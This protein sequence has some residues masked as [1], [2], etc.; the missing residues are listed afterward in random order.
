MGPSICIFNKVPS[1]ADDAGL[2]TTL[3]DLLLYTMR[4]LPTSKTSLLIMSPHT[5][6]LQ[7]GCQQWPWEWRSEEGG[8]CIP[9]FLLLHSLVCFSIP[10]LLNLF[11]TKL[12]WFLLYAKCFLSTTEDMT[13]NTIYLRKRNNI[14]ASLYVFLL[15]RSFCVNQSLPSFLCQKSQLHFTLLIPSL[16][17]YIHRVRKSPNWFSYSTSSLISHVWLSTGSFNPAFPSQTIHTMNPAIPAFQSSFR[18]HPSL[19][20]LPVAFSI[21]C[22]CLGLEGKAI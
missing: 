14:S 2:G 6:W 18:P 11:L 1:D 8:K 3:W 19:L 13:I 12:M 10:F 17:F 5:M 20:R 9:L 21:S 4:H 15:W 16:T 22:Q 7:P